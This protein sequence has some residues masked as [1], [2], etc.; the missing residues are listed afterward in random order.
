MT[1]AIHRSDIKI[2][3]CCTKK[4]LKQF[5]PHIRLR[6]QVSV[7]RTNGPLVSFVLL[8]HQNCLF[9]N[10]NKIVSFSKIYGTLLFFSILFHV[11]SLSH[12]LSIIIDLGVIMRRRALRQR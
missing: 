4:S 1:L 3:A 6:Y 2:K 12:H 9:M 7:Y 10:V 11:V 8:F 5:V